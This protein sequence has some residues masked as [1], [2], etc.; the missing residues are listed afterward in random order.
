MAHIRDE[1]IFLLDSKQPVIGYSSYLVTGCLPM[2]DR[3]E[4]LY[5]VEWVCT[6]DNKNHQI[7]GRTL[8]EAK[9]EAKKLRSKKMNKNVRIVARQQ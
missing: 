2:E 7:T 3:M 6:W 5:D 9:Y 4:K 8:A 1:R